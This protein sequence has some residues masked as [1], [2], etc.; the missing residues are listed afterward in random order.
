MPGVGY[1]EVTR[2]KGA[3]LR[4]TVFGMRER[5][6]V[7]TFIALRPIEDRMQGS[8]KLPRQADASQGHRVH[9]FSACMKE[10][11]SEMKIEALLPA[12]VPPSP[13]IVFVY[14]SCM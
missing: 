3:I 9:I 8:W 10:R 11:R 12:E 7:K 13:L 2:S 1:K 6:A 4:P 14:A 5:K